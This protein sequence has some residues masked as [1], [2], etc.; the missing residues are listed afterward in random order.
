[1]AKRFGKEQGRAR[2]TVG[3][4]DQLGFSEKTTEDHRHEWNEGLDNRK[5]GG[6]LLNPRRCYRKS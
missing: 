5:F 1:M 2:V 6:R 4:S 3:D